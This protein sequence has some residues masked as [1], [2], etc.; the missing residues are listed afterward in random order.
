MQLTGLIAA[1]H[2]PFHT[3]HSLNTDA[4]APLAA[5]L[6]ANGV[7]GVFVAGTTGECQSLTTAERGELFQAWGEAARVN[8]LTFIAHVGHNC[9]PDGRTLVEAAQ[10]AGADAIGAMAPT[11]FKPADA[12]DLV[13]W[14]SQ[15][16]AP[17]PRLPFYFY[18]IPPM[19]GVNIDTTELV[20]RAGERIE[21][22]V[23]V[24][25]TNSDRDQLRAILALPNHS[26]DMLWGCDEE[27]LDGLGLGCAGAVGSS[28]NFAAP[29]YHPI[30]KAHAEGDLETAQLWQ[31]R[32]VA[33]IDVLMARGYMEHAKA[34]MGLVGVECGP[35]RSPLGQLANEDKESL[36]D[37]LAALGFFVWVG[38]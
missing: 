33:V 35:A 37:E 36:R 20:Q 26:P 24:K 1:P 22:F 38:A 27:L 9:L 13:D 21:G 6:A 12:A 16:V 4:V 32:S 3:D 11:F 14:F 19:T 28:Y 15:L 34:V 5:H 17:A 30:L 10:S 23:G 31:S 7:N 8:G 18:D 2:T 25:Y 29:L